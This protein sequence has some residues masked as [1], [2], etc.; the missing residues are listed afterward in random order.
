MSPGPDPL[1]GSLRESGPNRSRIDLSGVLAASTTRET[2]AIPTANPKAVKA[3][4]G[5]TTRSHTNR[6]PPD[7]APSAAS[8]TT[9]DPPPLP[10]RLLDRSDANI[11]AGRYET[12]T[13]PVMPARS[14]Q[15]GLP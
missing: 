6:A 10:A 9:P 2:L 1:P 4:V 13:S 3:N 15:S 7:P 8:E 5:T 14:V 12:V 11:T